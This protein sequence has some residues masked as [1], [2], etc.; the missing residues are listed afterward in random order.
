MSIWFFVPSR[1][2]IA[3]RNLRREGLEALKALETNKEISQDEHKQASTQ[4]QKI[5]DTYIAGTDQLGKEK[6]TELRQV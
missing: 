4:L 5:T 3:I 1:R 2:K 6:E